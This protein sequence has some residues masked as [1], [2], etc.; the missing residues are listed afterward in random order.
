MDEVCFRS[1]TELARALR[2]GEV[3]A[4]EVLDAHLRQIERANPAV[5]AIVTLVPERAI[6]QARAADEAL[7]RGDAIGALHGLPMA[8]KDLVDTAGIRTTYGSPI[9]ADH[10]PD[11][12]EP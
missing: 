5:N 12:D 8:H 4:R 7:A 10:V 9:Y 3:S 1:A 11:V 6:A 2:A